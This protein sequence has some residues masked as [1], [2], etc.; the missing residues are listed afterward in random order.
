MSKILVVEDERPI[1]EFVQRGLEEEGYSVTCA[2][3][4]EEGLA[5]GA[6]FMQLHADHMPGW[7][8]AME[9]REIAGSMT[10]PVA[11]AR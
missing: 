11:S 7:E 8:G 6:E 2:Y 10:R 9:M 1:A 3:D 4:G 5:L